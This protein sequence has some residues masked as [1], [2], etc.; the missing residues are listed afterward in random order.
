[1]RLIQRTTFR[2]STIF[3]GPAR[4]GNYITPLSSTNISKVIRSFQLPN[5]KQCR[6]K[7]RLT[8]QIQLSYITSLSSAF[9]RSDRLT[10]LLGPVIISHL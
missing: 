4:T 3:L 5:F 6:F 9:S 8:Q 2:S 7:L 1:M 10:P